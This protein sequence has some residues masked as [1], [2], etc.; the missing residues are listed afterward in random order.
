MQQISNQFLQFLQQG[1]ASIFKFVQ[2]IWTWS[3]TEIGRVVQAP[4]Q[5]WPLWKQVLMVLVI[6]GVVWALFNAAKE[7]WAAAERTLAAFASLLAVLIKTLPH[8]ALAGLIA[9]AGVWS[10]NHI[11]LSQIQTPVAL[12]QFGF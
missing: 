4:W 10:I 6:A 3:I 5:N 1:I 8:V 11:N 9:L 12:K 7:L 2:L